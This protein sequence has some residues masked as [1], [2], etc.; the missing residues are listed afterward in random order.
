MSTSTQAPP[1]PAGAPSP[2]VPLLEP[3]GGDRGWR[4]PLRE[5]I[6]IGTSVLAALAGQ[7]W[8]ENGQERARERDY[9]QQLLADTRENERRLDLV[10]AE[11]S[12]SMEA[13]ANVVRA[14]HTP[15]P[16]PPADSLVL[17][18]LIALN[19]SDFQPVT[20]TY[21]ALL[22]A[23]DLRLLRNDSLR[24]KVVAYAATLAHERDM[25]LLFL[26]GVLNSASPLAQALPFVQ[27][28]FIE[29]RS[30]LNAHGFDF[31]AHRK[32]PELGAALFVLQVANRNRFN[33]L[34]RLRERTS[35][36]RQA[37]QQEPALARN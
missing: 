32:D 26:Q 19:S 4:I 31:A 3:A 35:E 16:L 9:L 29:D 5:F 14:L 7:A 15:G 37:L 36:L 17:W 8:W 34:S 23:G 33:H 6:V 22:S 1:A 27:R 11:D 12:A 21:E 28:V 30:K 2:T 20:G 24:G 25:L 13:V 10:I 18:T